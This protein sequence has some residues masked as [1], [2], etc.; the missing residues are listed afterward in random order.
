MPPRAEWRAVDQGGS[1]SRG[2]LITGASRGVGAAAAQAFA[3][4]GDRVVLHCRGAV[5][6][7]EDVRAALPG[8]GHAVI[9][10]DLG[11]PAAIP[12]LVDESATTLGR[13]DVLV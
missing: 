7:A 8:D 11:D 4:A 9:A 6:R 10:A 1:V 13:I 2:V 3:R 12:A 5:D